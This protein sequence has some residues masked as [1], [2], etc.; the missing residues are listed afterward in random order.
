M[1]RKVCFVLDAGT[2]R[3]VRLRSKGRLPPLAPHRLAAEGQWARASEAELQGR[4]D[5]G[6]G[7]MQKGTVRPGVTGGLTRIV[8]T[9][10]RTTDSVQGFPNGSVVKNLPAKQKTWGRSLRWEDPREK[11][12]TAPPQYSC[13]RKSM[14]RRAWQ[15]ESNASYR[16]ND[17]D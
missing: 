16:L 4:V 7:P 17:N 14:D 13:L 8:L 12:V 5:A 1:R 15:A 9:V 6:K 11:E 10:L 2:Q 3:G